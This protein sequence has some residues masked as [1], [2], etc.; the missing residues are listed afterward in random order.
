LI[1]RNQSDEVRFTYCP[2]APHLFLFS[3]FSLSTAW[4][5]PLVPVMKIFPGYNSFFF[6][7]QLSRKLPV[8]MIAAGT[9]GPAVY[10]ATLRRLVRILRLH[11]VLSRSKYTPSLCPS[12]HS[13]PPFAKFLAPAAVLQP[14]SME[15][16][17]LPKP[18]FSLFE[19][20]DPPPSPHRSYLFSST[21][22]LPIF[23]KTGVGCRGSDAF[24]IRFGL[25]R[26]ILPS[27]FFSLA[28]LSLYQF[29]KAPGTRG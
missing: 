23:P 13:S 12:N 19:S 27:G 1:S 6:R 15:F 17:F 28:S 29:A 11:D 25:R 9:I 7:D 18:S 10:V 21:K 3:L 5:S 8:P 20:T 24:Q 2:T 26:N 4:P 14:R 22:R 16:F